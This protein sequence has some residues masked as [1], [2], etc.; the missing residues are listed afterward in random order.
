MSWWGPLQQRLGHQLAAVPH[1]HIAAHRHYCCAQVG[2]LQ[3]AISGI[4]N[5]MLTWHAPSAQVRFEGLLVLCYCNLLPR[6]WHSRQIRA[7]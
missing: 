4:K 1:Y 5:S 6:C 7:G 3:S 2:Q